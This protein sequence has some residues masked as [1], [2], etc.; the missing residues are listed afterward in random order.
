MVKSAY[1]VG[2]TTTYVDLSVDR[3]GI[4]CLCNCA[5]RYGGFTSRIESAANIS[6]WQ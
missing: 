6:T 1:E 2:Q 3:K 5:L 4:E